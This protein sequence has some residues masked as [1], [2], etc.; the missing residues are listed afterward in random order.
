MD[1][2]LV[3]EAPPVYPP[4]GSGAAPSV[5]SAPY[6]TSYLPP[7]PPSQQQQQGFP[8]T[9]V[10]PPYSQYS[11]IPLNS[12]DARYYEH[13][14]TNVQHPTYYVNGQNPVVVMSACDAEEI[15]RRRRRVRCIS[16]I[17]FLIFFFTTFII[18]SSIWLCLSPNKE[19]ND[20]MDRN[21][22]M[23]AA[24]ARSIYEV[25]TPIKGGPSNGL[26]VKPLPPSANRGY[27]L[28]PSP[29]ANTESFKRSE[30][31]TVQPNNYDYEFK[32]EQKV[33][34]FTFFTTGRRLTGLVIICGLIILVLIAVGVA[35]IAAF[36]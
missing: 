36:S 29:T 8:S 6:P 35:L 16:L 25:D 20:I 30:I 33:H 7:Q 27:G 17:T 31:F 34:P 13:P 9:A 14:T 22:S 23:R 21:A 4:I 1:S 24:S 28:P 10:P 19:E 2:K 5:P 15:C 26:Y 3:G 11:E 12:T 18:C 32:H